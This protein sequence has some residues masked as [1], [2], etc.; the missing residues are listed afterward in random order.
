MNL[1]TKFNL[2]LIPVLL[3]SGVLAT[4]FSFD[5]LEKNAEKEIIDRAEIMM[6]SALA[7]RSYTVG[8]IRPLLA[9][10]MKREF[11]PQSVPAYGATQIFETLRAT[12]PE[13][14]YKEATLNPTNPRNRAVDWETDVVNEFIKDPE[15]GELFGQRDTPGGR[16]LYYAKP[17]AIKKEGCLACHS[18]VDRAP[19]SMLKLYGDANGFG[20]KL[21]EIVGAQIISVPMSVPIAHAQQALERFVIVLAVVF[22]AVLVIVNLMLRIIVTGPVKRMASVA[23]EISKGGTD[24]P[25]FAES[26]KDEISV[27]GG[28][29][30]RMRRSLD[31]AMKMLEE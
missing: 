1:T 5:I 8:E 18:T 11:R 17:I 29:F 26:G 30:N 12:H 23:D 22:V 6:E 20:W 4:Y 25:E 15:K 28:S 3:G 9:L 13:Y 10:Q 21:N 7:M 24:T 14:T 2:V 31:R 16:S 27:L 19:E